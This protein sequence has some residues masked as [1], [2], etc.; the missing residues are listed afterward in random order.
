MIRNKKVIRMKTN[1]NL[2]DQMTNIKKVKITT[3]N[4]SKILM[5]VMINHNRNKIKNIKLRM[6]NQNIQP[7]QIKIDN[8]IMFIVIVKL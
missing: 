8:N 7:F 6:I 4:I 2:I 5:I 1:M 3:K